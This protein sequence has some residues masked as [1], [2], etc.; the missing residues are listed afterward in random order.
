MI[1]MGQLLA[2][3]WGDYILQSHW[4]ASNKTKHWYPCLCHCIFYTLPFLFLTQSWVALSVIF[5]THYLI[6]RYRLVVYLIYFKNQ[7][8][9]EPIF[10]AFGKSDKWEDCKATGYNSEVPAWLSVWLM[11]FADNT[12]HLTI[13]YFCLTYL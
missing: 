12:L 6:D 11:I 1:L 9:G 7:V 2:H 4:M 10:K 3:L 5:G 8:L 13:N